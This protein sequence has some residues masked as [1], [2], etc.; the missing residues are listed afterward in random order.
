[1]PR[2]IQRNA[3]SSRHGGLAKTPASVQNNAMLPQQAYRH[4]ISG[5]GMRERIYIISDN[6]KGYAERR[7]SGF[8]WNIIDQHAE[9]EDDRGSKSRASA[10]ESG[11]P[12]TP[13]ESGHPRT[14]RVKNP[15]YYDEAERRL[16]SWLSSHPDWSSL[17]QAIPQQL[18]PSSITSHMSREKEIFGAAS[19]AIATLLVG[20]RGA[21]I[22]LERNLSIADFIRIDPTDLPSIGF[23]EE[24]IRSAMHIL[25]WRPCSDGSDQQISTAG[26]TTTLAV[27]RNRATPRPSQY[28]ERQKRKHKPPTA[29]VNEGKEKSHEQDSSQDICFRSRGG[30]RA[31]QQP[32]K[33]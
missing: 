10:P 15:Q 9:A 27:D 28:R 5:D 18:R 29:G 21:S 31:A 16:A 24:E 20:Q 13:E 6:A 17:I 1:M 33:S 32:R 3:E 30:F 23:D 8:T 22:F 25:S 14:S 11:K 19:L 4:W 12:L 26:H 7:G 2:E